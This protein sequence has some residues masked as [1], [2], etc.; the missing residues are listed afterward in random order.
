MIKQ[1]TLLAQAGS[2]WDQQTGAVNMPL[3]SSSIFRHPKLGQS[4]GFDY[5]RSNNPT[6]AVLE[7]IF[8]ELEGGA[9]AST[10]ASGLAAIDAV[11]HIFKPGDKLLVTEDLYGGTIR[12]LD[13]VYAQY[14]LE[15][16]Y[17]DTSDLNKVKE[18]F[19]K[20]TFQGVFIEVPTNP[21][22][23]VADIRAIAELSKKQNALLIVDNTFLTPILC[24]PLD[25]GADIVVHSTT[26]YLSGHNDLIG[27]AAIA[28]DEEI[29][30]LINYYQNT[31]GAVPSPSDCWLLLRSLK[32]L[33]L[34]VKQHEKNAMKIALFLTQQ[35]RVKKV[36]YPGLTEDPGHETLK[37]QS[38]G[39]GAM[40]SIEVD[41]AALVPRILE[42]IK[43]FFF[44]E[45]LGGTESLI[46][47]PAVQT[48]FDI[49]EEER[50]RLG[51]SNRLL[52]ISI[53]LED[54]EDLIADLSHALR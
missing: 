35:K 9:G 38:S 21:L 3:Y 19:S 39:F 53:G 17:V 7:D 20:Q 15:I 31:I 41:D 8:K 28:K 30:K 37:K 46:T 29:A 6:R 16:V 14:G 5:A 27:G 10:F 11:L 48:H 51:I 42:E 52:R 44:A 12:L 13:K 23:K 50:N 4:T 32:T 24:R 45:S 33:S 25:L 1:D 26:K 36:F 49:P 18:A 22:L 40:M 2:H 34:R 43:V 47:F 54:T